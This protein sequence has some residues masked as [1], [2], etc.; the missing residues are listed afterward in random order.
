MPVAYPKR[1]VFATN[2]CDYCEKEYNRLAMSLDSLTGIK[3]CDLHL[4]WGERDVKAWYHTMG[5]IPVEEVLTRYNLPSKDLVVLRS[6]GSTSVGGYVI[7]STNHDTKFVRK[8]LGS[9]S[10]FLDVG[11]I[12]ALGNSLQKSLELKNLVLS[13]VES[14]LINSIIADLEDGLFNNEYQASLLESEEPTSI[15]KELEGLRKVYVEGIGEGLIL[16]M[17]GQCSGRDRLL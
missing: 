4:V 12:G 5:L 14:G 2:K 9:N 11:F 13:G 15:D 7:K 3:C 6:D 8:D 16:D 17:R 10:W 1:I